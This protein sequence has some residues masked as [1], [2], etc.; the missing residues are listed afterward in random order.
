MDKYIVKVDGGRYLVRDGLRPV[1]SKDAKQA[2]QM[3]R[4]M[5]HVV[6][7]RLQRLRYRTCVIA[8]HEMKHEVALTTGGE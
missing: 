3:P 4:S 5:A 8:V 6:A 7:G 2:E 1:L